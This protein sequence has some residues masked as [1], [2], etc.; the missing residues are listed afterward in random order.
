[1]LGVLLIIAL[2]FGWT[3]FIYMNKTYISIYLFGILTLLLSSNLVPWKIVQNTPLDTLQFPWRLIILTNIL[4]AAFFSHFCIVI[5]QRKNIIVTLSLL[6][7]PIIFYYSSA[8]S[9]IQSVDQQENLNFKPGPNHS[10]YPYKVSSK[11]Y[12]NQFH[13]YWTSGQI[14]Y[15][16]KKSIPYAD[17]IIKHKIRINGIYSGD[18][19][20]PSVVDNSITF[21]L[22]SLDL[23]KN[24]TIDLPFLA[25]KNNQ[26]RINN[27]ISEYSISERGT[28]KV[29]VV[30]SHN[31]KIIIKYIPSMVE[32]LSI[33]ISLLSI[34]GVFLLIIYR[35]RI[36]LFVK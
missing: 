13:Y 8:Q 10:I 33:W 17:E 16:P 34:L 3:A 11:T 35:D 15:F 21:N 2:L 12:K 1:N 24:D 9:F 32:K 27:Y 23:K 25:Y 19:V 5:F 20:I 4:F 6:L 30:N 18:I 14:D 26:V 22:S 28:I 7:L 36:K 29:K 31:M